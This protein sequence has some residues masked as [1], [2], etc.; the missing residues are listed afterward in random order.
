[1]NQPLKILHITDLHLFGDPQ[2][3]LVGINPLQT[4]KKVAS[5]ILS[6][7]QQDKPDLIMLTGDISQDYSPESYKIAN[8]I[9]RQ[10][11]FPIV[12][13]MGNHDDPTHFN[14]TFGNSTQFIKKPDLTNWQ[15]IVLNSFWQQHVGG[16]LAYQE[17]KFL[18]DSLDKTDDHPVIIFLH[19]HVVSI[20]SS[21]IDKI[22][23]NNNSQ[24]LEIIDQYKNIKAVVSGHV[25]QDTQVT[26]KG[27]DFYSSPSTS[28]QFLVRSP[29][30]KLDTSMPGY[31]WINLNGDGTLNTKVVRIEHDDGFVPDTKSTGY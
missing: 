17:L 2:A 13:T 31:R 28:W 10:F 18:Q 25:H 11:Q 19:H 3:K 14:N 29:G 22:N 30:F 1:M 26:R 5:K 16:K 9:M 7:Y 24:F 15:I 12:A 27:V 4:L 21:W 8:K 6:N 23:L 20:D